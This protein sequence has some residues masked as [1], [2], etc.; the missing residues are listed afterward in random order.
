MMR[1]GNIRKISFF[2]IAVILLCAMIGFSYWRDRVTCIGVEILSEADLEK[3]TEYAHRDVAKDLF[4][5]GEPAAVDVESCTIYIPQAITESTTPQN[6]P[7]QLRLDATRYQIYFAPDPQFGDLVA[8]AET[9]HRFALYVTSGSQRYMKY[10]VVFTTLPVMR[11]DGEIL[12][13]KDHWRNYMYGPL[14][15]WHPNDPDTGRYSVR[16]SNAEW[17]IRGGFSTTMDKRSWRVS[18]KNKHGEKRDMAFAGLGAD[19]DWIL[20]PMSLDDTF[21]KEKLAMQLWNEMAE[22]SP[23]N[24]KMSMGEY[25]EVVMNGSYEGIHLLQRKIEADVIG[26]SEED[27][28]IKGILQKAEGRQVSEVL[29]IVESPLDDE[30]TFGLAQGILD[31]SNCDIMSL[32]NFIDVQ[33]FLDWLNAQ[34]NIG[35]KNTYYVLKP[36]ENGYQMVLVPWDTDMSLGVVW[37][38]EINNFAYFLGC[39]DT[40]AAERMELKTM[41]QMYPELD[42]KMAKRWGELRETIFSVAHEQEIVAALREQLE[43]SG[44]LERDLQR[45]GLVYGGEDS[46]ENLNRYLTAR[47]QWMDEKYAVAG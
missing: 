7:G 33:L 30:T 34:D 6:M 41:R 17:S 16:S 42:A 8:A 47:F 4:F 28:L 11:V 35:Y 44:A 36:A 10:D 19:D 1:G 43:S 25:V 39:V 24:Y 29:E 46:I 37:S 2:L 31:Y 20:N 3:F 18:L 12:R 27:I 9:G 38:A 40:I 26:A 21:V 14:C 45:W 5:N 23:W 15:L 13:E 22:Q 32:E